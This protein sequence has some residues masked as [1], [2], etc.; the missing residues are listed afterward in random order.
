MEIINYI[1]YESIILMI[2]MNRFQVSW[3]TKMD[4]YEGVKEIYAGIEKLIK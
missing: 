4:K 1:I 2:K 3:L